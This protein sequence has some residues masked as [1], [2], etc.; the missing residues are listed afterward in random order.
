[1][2]GLKKQKHGNRQN[3]QFQSSKQEPKKLRGDVTP[4]LLA[5]LTDIKQLYSRGKIP[6][7]LVNIKYCIHFKSTYSTCDA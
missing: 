6:I 3:T 5:I 1:M 4:A 2:S 7:L